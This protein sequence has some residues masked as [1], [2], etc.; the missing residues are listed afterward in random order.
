M[1]PQAMTTAA[2]RRG[3]QHA[4]DSGRDIVG[5]WLGMDV[6]AA[7]LAEAGFERG[8]SPW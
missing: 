3:V 7:P 6:D 1:F 5:A 2:V 8:W 4:R